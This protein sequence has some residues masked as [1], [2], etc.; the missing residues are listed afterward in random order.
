MSAA[1]IDHYLAGLDETRRETLEALRTSILRA[2]PDAEQGISYAV[3]AFREDGGVIAG[4]AAFT[5]HLAYLPHSGAV[6]ATLA[7]ELDGY[8]RT[9][10]S[11]HFPIDSPLDDELV[12]RLIEAK[13]HVL[14]ERAA[15]RL[16]K[17]A[18]PSG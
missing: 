10:G 5:S 3:P 12:A 11:L 2:A 13:R 6:L 14:A 1:E 4:F 15:G 8:T 7:D 9:A 16:T 17:R 18:R